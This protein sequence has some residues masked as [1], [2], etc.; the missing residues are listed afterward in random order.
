MITAW[1]LQWGMDDDQS[2]TLIANLCNGGRPVPASSQRLSY[3]STIGP[4]DLYTI[5]RKSGGKTAALQMGAQK[6]VVRLQSR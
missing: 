5:G 1:L 3:A 4:I 2:L 6:F